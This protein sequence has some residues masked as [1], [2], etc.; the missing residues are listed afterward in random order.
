MFKLLLQHLGLI[1]PSVAKF[2]VTAPDGDVYIAKVHYVGVFDYYA[3]LNYLK[4][5][6]NFVPL[7][8]QLVG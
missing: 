2:E 3:V 5:S 6:L 7:N 1:K 8:I 4:D